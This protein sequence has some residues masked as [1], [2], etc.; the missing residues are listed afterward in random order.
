MLNTSTITEQ[1]AAHL[2]E[3]LSRGR[4][5][6]L[7]PGR[8]RLVAELGVNGRTIEKALTM[9]EQEGL[10]Q[11]QGAGRRRLITRPQGK[12]LKSLTIQLLLYEEGE[13]R[14]PFLLDLI[15]ELRK[16]GITAVFAD[17][18]LS[19]LKMDLTKVIRFVNRI[20][21][22]MWLV[23]GASGE[24]LEWFASRSVPAYAIF[25]RLASVNI[26]GVGTLKSPA[27]EQAVRRLVELGHR[28]IVMMTRPERRSPDPGLF[29]RQFLDSLAAS[30]IAVG[31]YNLPDWD[32]DATSF[33]KCLD[34]LF[35]HT[36]PT[37][38][39]FSEPQLYVSALHYFCAR[40]LRVPK[41]VSMICHD[42][43]PV[44]DW[45]MPV[46][47]HLH[48]DRKLL[49]RHVLRWVKQVARGKASRRQT[50]IKANFVEGETI[51]P[52]LKLRRESK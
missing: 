22:D 19:D 50:L 39:F 30:G 1:V 6:G 10:L 14:Q 3:D 2:R 40:G 18:T 20:E 32:D 4:W 25:G 5:T 31:N 35:T 28:R 51:G 47:S 26:A 24:I 23:Q 16:L 15:H 37:A 43:D 49:A 46:V 8:D 9:L 21:A 29:E 45:Q 41:D 12:S 44:F 42:A 11:S 34:S 13:S 52:A 27:M 33:R 36:P 38:I 7:M 48:W 17:K